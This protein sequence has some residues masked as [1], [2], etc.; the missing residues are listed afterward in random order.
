MQA[1]AYYAAVTQLWISSRVHG[2][3]AEQRRKKTLKP[4]QKS[5][6]FQDN[7]PCCQLLPENGLR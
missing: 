1:P 7:K 3:I 4:N 5:Y 2:G 6:Y